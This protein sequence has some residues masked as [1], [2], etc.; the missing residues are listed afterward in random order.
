MHS[1]LFRLSWSSVCI[2]CSIALLYIL[3][4]VL[5]TTHIPLVTSRRLVDR[6]LVAL[7]SQLLYWLLCIT[8][9]RKKQVY[10]FF[11]L[12]GIATLCLLALISY[13]TLWSFILV[14]LRTWAWQHLYRRQRQWL[15]NRRIWSTR[16]YVYSQIGFW[17]PSISLLTVLSLVS[18]LGNTW[19]DCKQLEQSLRLWWIQQHIGT[20]SL[21]TVLWASTVSSGE[22]LSLITQ[23]SSW[24]VLGFLTKTKSE[25][26]DLIVEQ[27]D[28]LNHSVCEVINTQLITIQHRHSRQAAA[29][30][31]L[32]ILVRPFISILIRASIPAQLLVWYVLWLVWYVKKQTKWVLIHSVSLE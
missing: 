32:Y 16:W 22:S 30:L 4:I 8:K 25:I 1:S 13:V 17:W 6:L 9:K 27:K 5:I 15:L 23:D 29:I 7:C 10:I 3:W 20:I 11:T 21:W 14:V 24:W 18:T 19:I 2:S 26:Y 28:L 31:L 12:L